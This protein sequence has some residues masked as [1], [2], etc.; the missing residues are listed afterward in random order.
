MVIK[1]KE[2]N[3]LLKSELCSIRSNN[4]EFRIRNCEPQPSSSEEGKNHRIAKEL[5]AAAN[6]AE[7]SLRSLLGGIENL[8][9]IA[10]SMEN[11]NKFEDEEY[12]HFLGEDS[13]SGPAL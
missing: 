4:T 7:T 2:E 3:K 9:M 8:R 11:V 5:R 13:A 1:L 10:S 6:L 12:Q